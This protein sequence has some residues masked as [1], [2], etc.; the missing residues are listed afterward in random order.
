MY[1]GI[2]MSSTKYLDCV[3][4]SYP[5]KE[6][7]GA[8]CK[9]GSSTNIRWKEAGLVAAGCCKSENLGGIFCFDADSPVAVII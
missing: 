7:H 8:A 3:V 2:T 9:K 5:I 4:I 1:H 6:S